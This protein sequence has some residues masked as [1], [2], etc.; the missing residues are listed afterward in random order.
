M[1]PKMGPEMGPKMGLA[2]DLVLFQ[3]FPRFFS[4]PRVKPGAPE[5]FFY[6]T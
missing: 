5:I 2:G 6:F 4:F 3:V 1:G